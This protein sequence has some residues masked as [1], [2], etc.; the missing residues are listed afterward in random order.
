M[1]D[2]CSYSRH[3][4]AARRDGCPLVLGLAALL[5]FALPWPYSHFRAANWAD[6]ILQRALPRVI[7]M[8][9]L[10]GLLHDVGVQMQRRRCST[11]RRPSCDAFA[12]L[13]LPPQAALAGHASAVSTAW[14]QGSPADWNDGASW[15]G[16]G[17]FR[18]ANRVEVCSSNSEPL[19]IPHEQVLH[20]AATRLCSSESGVECDFKS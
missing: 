9:S 6:P 1:C 5:S 11:R 14:L 7:S 15:S 16:G 18:E 10:L 4:T 19:E 12:L 3:C 17:S 2:D 20:G 13:L 8:I